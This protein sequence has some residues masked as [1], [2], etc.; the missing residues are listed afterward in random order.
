[1]RLLLLLLCLL[2]ASASWAEEQ[3][4][5]FLM[6]N[7]HPRAIVVELHS[8]TREHRWPGG[9]KVYLLE[10]DERKSVPITCE[11]GEQICYA[12]WVNG[13]DGVF[14]GVGPDNNRTCDDCCTLCADKATTEFTIE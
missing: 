9:D 6:K 5:S 11:G 13:N 7:A 8:R 12:A 10:P 4:M 3:S 2:P 14:W 1:M